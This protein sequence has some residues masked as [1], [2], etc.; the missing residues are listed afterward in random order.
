M[1]IGTVGAPRATLG[2][3]GYAKLFA[4]MKQSGVTVFM[5]MSL[6]EETPAPVGTGAE[7][8]IFPPPFGSATPEFYAA[9]RANGVTFAIP[10]DLI[11]PAGQP[12]PAPADDP[13][14]AF[15]AAAGRDLIA[16]VYGYDEPAHN[17]LPV[18]ASRAVYQHVKAIDASIPVL[19]VHAPVPEGADPAGYL[20]AVLSHAA[21]ADAVGFAVYPYAPTPGAPT[22]Y[23]GGALVEPIAALRDYAR[24]LDAMLPDKQHIGVLQGF[25]FAD[26][27]SDAL[28][29]TVDPRLAAA[30]VAPTPAQMEAMVAALSDMDALYWFGP[31]YLDPEDAGVWADILAASEAFVAAPAAPVA[32]VDLDPALNSVSEAA[33]AGA[34]IGLVV[35]LESSGAAVGFTVSDSRFAVA[36][37]GVVTLAAGRSLDYEAADA[38]P[39]TISARLSDGRVA[40]AAFTVTVRDAVEGA[41]GT[42]RADSL[43]GGRGADV[44]EGMGGNDTLTGGGGT[45]TLDGGA[46]RDRLLG[47]AGSDILIGDLAEDTLQGGAGDDFLSGGA[48]ADVFQFA[49]GHGADV[50]IDFQRGS[51]RIQFTGGVTV[52]DIAFYDLGSAVVI[53]YGPD[54]VVVDGLTSEG[55]SASDLLFG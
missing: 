42:S 17:G 41:V 24:W 29:A 48:G 15:I 5:P 8:D 43:T 23:S 40:E 38:I 2:G 9:A 7:A 53:G 27:Y 3:D 11:Y 32:L 19:Q 30:A 13:L 26:M 49:R 22:P 20:A 4:D 39:L 25:G 46:G 54:Y 44:M 52:G 12:L 36:A 16:G 1:Q 28:L 10:A 6:Y 55:W 51:D 47:G 37:N 14:R 50:I 45:D 31:S 18:A 21:W 33:A 35:G 34:S